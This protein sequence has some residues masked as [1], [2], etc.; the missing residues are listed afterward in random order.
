MHR[1]DQLGQRF[2]AGSRVSST[3]ARPRAPWPTCA[4]RCR[5]SSAASGVRVNTVSPGP[6]QTDLWLGD[7]GVA[8]TL[9]G[10]R[11]VS[12]QD[13]ADGSRRAARPAGSPPRTR[14]PT[15]SCS[16][17]ATA[18]RERHRQRLRHRRRPRHH[19]L[20]RPATSALTGD[21]EPPER[22][23]EG[24]PHDQSPS[25][26]S[27]A[28]GCTPP[29][30]SPGSSCSARPATTRSRPAGRAS[31][32]RS[33][34]AREQPGAVADIGIDDVTG[35][36]ADIIDGLDEPPV[37]I[38]HSFG[39]LIAEKLLGQGIG[40]AAV[41]IDPAQIKGVL[42]LPLA[43][44]RAGLPGAGQPGEPAQGRL[45]RPRR[46]SGS[47]SATRVTEEESDELYEQVDD[48]LAGPAA[49]PGGGREL[50]RCTPQ[51]KVDTDNADPRAAAADLRHSRTTPC[52][53]SSPARP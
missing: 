29:A 42:P 24:A 31:R 39:G 30:G 4:S 52:P 9:G 23:K 5:R 33:S 20:V 2:P 34:E 49:V 19:P 26:S 44:L 35:H 17:P 22:P 53:T 32:R 8:A 12:P 41:A 40:A 1:D 28:C 45:P 50:R 13:I 47:G 25:S 21:P 16:C 37:I 14:W 11:D 7:G 36:Y 46:S 48:P 27:T 43:Q 10:P 6:V 51:A 3:T 18:S 15:S 38:G